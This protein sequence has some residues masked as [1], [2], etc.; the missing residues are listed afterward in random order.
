[1]SGKRVAAMSGVQGTAPEGPPRPSVSTARK[2]AGSL[3]WAVALPAVIILGSGLGQWM[4]WLGVVVMLG[5]VA[6]AACLIGGVWHRAGAATLASVAGFGLML[7]AGPAVY[8]VYMKT[9]GDPVAAVVTEV[10]D[11]QQRRGADMFCTV[12]ER[13]GDRTRHE[14]SQQEN[15][16]GQAEVGDRVEIR[17]DPLGLFDPRLPDSPDQRNTTEITVAVTTG[18][19]LLTAAA[20]FYGGQRRRG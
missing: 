17:K 15:C 5:A 20:T 19:A 6:V 8:E 13:G 16:F 3:V 10:T 11:R 1:M 4:T 14:V 12:E 9:V 7:F 18:L 2:A